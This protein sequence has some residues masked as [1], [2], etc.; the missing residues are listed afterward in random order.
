[1][2]LV[3]ELYGLNLTLVASFVIFCCNHPQEATMSIPKFKEMDRAYGFDEVA[4]VPGDVTIN[5][6]QTNINFTVG[7]FTFSVPILAA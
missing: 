2:G 6:D 5:P 1:M 4:L 3:T 7:N